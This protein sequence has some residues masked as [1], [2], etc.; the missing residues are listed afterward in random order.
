MMEE[1]GSGNVKGADTD[2]VD[3]HEPKG[4]HLVLFRAYTYEKPIKLAW[5]GAIIFKVVLKYDKCHMTR[6]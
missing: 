3:L 5:N 1:M 4:F 2:E 6:M